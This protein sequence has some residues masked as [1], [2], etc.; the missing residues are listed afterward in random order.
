M[1]LIF[2]TYKEGDQSGI[3][4]TYTAAFCKSRICQPS[5]PEF[6]EWKYGV[7]RPYYTPKGYQ[8]CEYK[9]KIVG[10]II[11][12][13]RTMKFNGE[14]YKVAGIDDVATCPVLERRGIGR[15]LMENAI[16]FMKEDQ[17]VDLSIL[18]ADRKGHAK[19]I[20]WRLGYKYT[21]YFSIGAKIL[22]VYNTFKNFTPITPLALPLKL[23]GNIKTIRATKKYNG[24]LKLTILGKN[25]D[26][27]RQKLNENYRI[28]YSFNEFDPIYWKWYHIERPKSYESI[29]VAAKE[30]NRIVAGGVITKAFLMIFNSRRWFPIFHITELF[31]DKAY[32]GRGI[33][34]YLLSQ[35]ERIA[36]HQGVSMVLLHFH[37]QNHIFRNLIKKMGYICLHERSMQM[38]KPISERAKDLFTRNQGKKFIWKVPWE[39]LGY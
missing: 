1:N 20:Y 30:H 10:S 18:S 38:M 11:C 22:S 6:W 25:Q 27:F 9:G 37:G 4:K 17:K 2:R 13:I 8:I 33:G 5:T 24:N 26:K 15:R 21:T 32:R 3:L 16:K 34:S 36:K 14:V 31:V 19:K 39:Q 29:V 23:Y 28:F 7:R 35:L 12:T